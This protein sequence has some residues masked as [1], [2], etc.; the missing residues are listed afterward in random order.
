VSDVTHLVV[1]RDA[2]LAAFAPLFSGECL[3]GGLLFVGDGGI[4]KTTLL[5]RAAGLAK[6]RGFTVLCAR[7]TNAEAALSY[8][9]L[10]DLMSEP[11]TTFLSELPAPQR[12]S[13][14]EAL[15]LRDVRSGA[16]P[17]PRAIGVGFLNVLR[18]LSQASRLLVAVDDLQWVDPASA[19]VLSLALRRV[20]AEPIAVVFASRALP[21][22]P[23]R[24]LVVGYKR[25]ELGPLSQGALHQIIRDRTGRA[26]PRHQLRRVAE[27][28]GGNPFFALEFARS[29]SSE[30]GADIPVPTS[31]LA[32]VQC[33]IA[34]LPG[35]AIDGLQAASLCARPTLRV[36]GAVVGEG[37][38]AELMAA[39]AAGVLTIHDDRLEFAHPLYASAVDA[40]LGSARRRF[41]HA[42]I[43]Q[44]V[45][46][47]EERARHLALSTSPPDG[48]IA[49]QL[50]V[51]ARAAAGRGA[52]SASAEFAELAARFTEL[53]EPGLSRERRLF[54]VDLYLRA[55]E[56]EPA[57]DILARLESELEPGP[58][59]AA[60]TLRRF[61][62]FTDYATF[63]P[64]GRQAVGE[65]DADPTLRGELRRAVGIALAYTGDVTGALSE[66]RGAIADLDGADPAVAASAIGA[67]VLMESIAGLPIDDALLE[68]GLSVES[69]LGLPPDRHSPSRV[70]AAL[71]LHS[72]RYA[73]ALPQL[74]ALT[75]RAAEH[76]DE[77]LMLFTTFMK[78]Q[79]LC[80][81]GELRSARATAMQTVEL[82]GEL[83]LTEPALC[84]LAQA[85]AALGNGEAARAA[86][87]AAATSRANVLI[88]S[89]ATLALA[90]LALSLGD[91]STA[92][93]LVEPLHTAFR[94]MGR[95][96]PTWP[97][98]LPLAVEA[99]TLAGEMAAARP[100]L[101]HLEIV[102]ERIDNPLASAL[103]LRTRG[104]FA[105]AEGD[106]DLAF[107]S[108]NEAAVHH[109]EIS[110]HFEEA[111]LL[112]ARG[113]A[114]RRAK[115]RALARQTLIQAAERFEAFGARAWAERARESL[116]RVGGR[117][118]AGA[119]LTRSEE[120]VARLVGEGRSNKEIA[121][122]LF[123][124]V[125]TI[126]GALTR[127]YS[128]LGVRS[129]AE[130]V[131]KLTEDELLKL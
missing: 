57:S 25:F 81:L 101:E 127:I 38:E 89:D 7:P 105:A 32:L 78:V 31:L 41:L 42:R 3:P 60:I 63:V 43:A 21:P 55:G 75:G 28:S 124:S 4:G 114:E 130:L 90:E 62:R 109:V 125:K 58:E 10:G 79:S 83:G 68:R 121:A 51:A 94:E 17:D 86:V 61:N 71:L 74:D 12:R 116:A 33:V 64:L 26:L 77:T 34:G 2:E 92:S 35:R 126:E 22:S 72:G 73:D 131:R 46:D 98:P 103:A 56:W 82:A 120:R 19:S 20:R 40:M 39:V 107:H 88:G 95:E 37:V 113:Q 49:D 87:A 54:A 106:F 48:A 16:L 102:V 50:M 119:A 29:V 6:V 76:G 30:V 8:A 9:V 84:R 129:R 91:A 44:T 1:G 47:P 23:L 45:E 69:D 27:R 85:E 110:A 11:V 80:G 112:L 70:R 128:K 24:E 93:S 5:E 15:L 52:A 115:R 13:L 117:T 97:S 118:P 100:L 59:R 123:L 67:A 111:R 99:A 36:V 65:A 18:I 96:L 66:L 14:E 122:A 53:S 104:T 108:F